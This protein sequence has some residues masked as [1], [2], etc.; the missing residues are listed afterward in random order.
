M[1]VNID[2]INRIIV[3]DSEGNIIK[4]FKPSTITVQNTFDKSKILIINMTK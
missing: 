2:K 4:H 1:N 3:K